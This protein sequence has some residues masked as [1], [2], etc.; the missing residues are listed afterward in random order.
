M[1]SGHN[2]EQTKEYS[3]KYDAYYCV[4]CNE[5][6][7]DICTDRDCEFCKIRPLTPQKETND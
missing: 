4:S 2:C 1:D 7:E 3:E 5:W 6:L